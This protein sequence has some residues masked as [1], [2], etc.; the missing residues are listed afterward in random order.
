MFIPLRYIKHVAQSDLMWCPS[1][2][3]GMRAFTISELLDHH[4]RRTVIYNGIE[5]LGPFT[6][7]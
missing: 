4:D 6:N 5:Y 3:L 7:M 2:Q 1:A